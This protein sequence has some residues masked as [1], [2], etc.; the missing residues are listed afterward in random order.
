MGEMVF[1]ARVRRRARALW[2]GLTLSAIVAQLGHAQSFSGATGQSNLTGLPGQNVAQQMMAQSINNFCPTV[3]SIA[4]PTPGQTALK[5]LCGRMIGNALNV[6]GQPNPPAGSGSS[7]PLP[8]FGLDTGGLNGALSQLNGGAELLV[9]TS[10]ASV[11]QTTQ[12]SRQTGAIEERLKELRDW[13]TGTVLA[14][15][16]PPRT[17]QV[18]SLNTQEPG[19]E[20]RLAQNQPLEFAYST[21]AFGV[22]VSGLGQFGSRDQTTTENGYSFNN[23]GFIAGADYRFT[24][25]LI[26]GLA[27]GYTQSNTNFDTSALSASGQSLNGNLLQGN[28]YATYSVTDALYANAIGFIGGGNNNSQRHIALPNASDFVGDG[29]ATGSFGSRIA[30]FTLAAGY[31]LPYGAFVLTPIARFL[32]QHTGVDAFNEEG[33]LGADLAFGSSSVNTVLTFLGADAQYTMPT[34]F[35]VLFP[36]ARFHWAHQYSPGNTA[37]S[38][39]YSNDPTS[40]LSNFILPGTPTSRN[41]FD[42]GVGVSLPFSS[43]GSAYIN[44]D[45]ILGINST[46][47][48]SFTAGVR[49]TF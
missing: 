42:L 5:G 46:T 39:A 45:V 1:Q 11:V 8:S 38:V 24:P 2:L 27:F 16:E 3:T 36:I 32:Y 13:T 44:Y 26:A 20:P 7:S 37:V 18:A 14:G 48:N 35:G 25:Q 29:I 28:L 4:M 30:G 12:T 23:A 49:F 19:G 17:G 47:Y 43:N 41:Y 21:G 31:A 33:A 22:F 10:Q 6:L 34:P 15:A 40:V 9:P